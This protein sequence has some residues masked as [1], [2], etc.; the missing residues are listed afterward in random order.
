MLIKSVHDWCSMEVEV[1]NTMFNGT[2]SNDWY[3]VHI[4]SNT[5]LSN[6]SVAIKNSTFSNNK[7]GG[8]LVLEHVKKF[9][10]SGC[11]FVNN[12]MGSWIDVHVAIEDTWYS[13][14]NDCLISDNNDTFLVDINPSAGN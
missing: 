12:H 5:K 1:I 4:V 13:E 2:T 14:I 8:A 11:S 3:G 9:K 7:H 10:I 6:I